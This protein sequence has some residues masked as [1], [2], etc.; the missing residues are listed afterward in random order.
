MTGNVTIASAA[1][2][3]VRADI[4]A[5]RL[6][7]GAKLRI[8]DVCQR[9]EVSITPMREALNRLAS[10]QLVV[11][12][13]QRGFAV[14]GISRAQLEEL[15]NTRV[16]LNDVALRRSI[17]FGDLAWEEHVLLSYHRLAR[18]PRYAGTAD[19]E[20]N[21]DWDPPHRAFHSALNAA[22]PSR[23]ICGYCDQLFDQSS[24]YRNL[25]RAIVMKE[26]GDLDEHRPIMEAVI[27]RDADRAVA[28]MT[29]HVTETTKILLDRWSDIAAG[30]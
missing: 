1:Y 10:E 15:T 11:L 5:G 17:E 8:R 28:L 9:Y 14:S 2:Q 21:P 3:Q 27:A 30:A 12:N 6:T 16:W 23:W 29:R 7:P 26:R 20:L 24:R 22:C 4:I 25:S 18:V 19:S 13:D